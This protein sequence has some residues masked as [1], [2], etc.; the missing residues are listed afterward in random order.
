MKKFFLLFVLTF[1]L[2]L[3]H[4]SKAQGGPG[5][6]GSTENVFWFSS[7][8]FV[9][10]DG[11]NNVTTWRDQ[12][13]SNDANNNNSSTN[14]AF[15]AV[16]NVGGNLQP[17]ILFSS[18]STEFL[19]M[20]D[21]AS[22]NLTSITARTIFFVFRTG[23]DVAT[24]QYLYQQGA[25]VDGVFAYISGS[26]LTFGINSAS[27]NYTISSGVS[28]DTDYIVGFTY[29]G[30]AQTLDL[31]LN[32]TAATQTT[33]VATSIASHTNI[34]IGS[35]TAGT[36]FL[37]GHLA[38]IIYYDVAFNDAELRVVDNYLSEKYDIAI[39][40][41]HYTTADA[42]YGNN[43]VGISRLSGAEH[44]ASTGYGGSLYISE[45]TTD[46][47]TELIDDEHIYIGHNNNNQ[48]TTS[49]DMGAIANTE[50]Y[51]RVWYLLETG[52]AGA[53]VEFDL[54]ESGLY[55]AM[56]GDPSVFSLLFRA[57]VSGDFTDTDYTSAVKALNGD[58]IQ[59][60]IS[61]T[62][63]KS[64]YITI[65]VPATSKKWYV[66][67][68]GN[69]NDPNTW[70]LDPAGSIYNNPDGLTP[71]SSPTT[72]S[73]EVT[74]LSGK[75]VTVQ[76]N[77]M[78]GTLAKLTVDG[79]LDF[80][81]STGHGAVSLLEGSGVIKLSNDILPTF[82][83]ASNFTSTGSGAGTVE[84]YGSS[85]INL[86]ASS[87][88]TS[89][90]NLSLNFDANSDHLIVTTDITVNGDLTITT[91]DF[92]INDLSTTRL[93]IDVQG[94]LTVSANGEISVGTGAISA[95]QPVGPSDFHDTFHRLNLSGD[96]TN[97]GT[98]NFSNLT[99]YDFRNIPTNNDCVTV[100]FIGQSDNTLTCN[101]TT[102]F[103]DFVINKGN[104]K[105]YSLTVNPSAYGNFRVF[106]R[107]DVGND[108]NFDDPTIGKPIAII[109]GTLIVTGYTFIPSLSEGRTDIINDEGNR[110]DWIIPASSAFWINGPNVIVHGTSN[111]AADIVFIDTDLAPEV[112]NIVGVRTTRASQQSFIIMGEF[113][114]S[115]GIYDCR[116]APG[117][118]FSQYGS[119]RFIIEG[120][121]MKVSQLRN[122]N[123]NASVAYNQ[124]G[125][126][127]TVIGETEGG[128]TSVPTIG[129]F[130]FN[131][132]NGVFIM[133]GGNI[134]IKD[135][136]DTA[137]GDPGTVNGLNINVPEGNYNVT[138]GT[139]EID[140]E[141]GD[142]PSEGFEI[143]FT[144]NFYNLTISQ[145]DNDSISFE[146]NVVVTNDLILKAGTVIGM[147]G[148]DLTVGR[149][150]NV[151]AT[152]IYN[153]N[154]TSGSNTTTF[155][156]DAGQ[157]IT[158]AGTVTDNFYDIV[159]S[160]TGVKTISSA[161]LTVVNSLT[162]AS[163]ATLDDGGQNIIVQGSMSNSGTHQSTGSGALEF[164]GGT[165]YTVSG[166]DNGVFGDVNLNDGTND[167][168]FTADQAIVGTLTFVAD[169]QVLHIGTH[170]LVMQGAG[171]LISGYDSN[172][173]IQTDGNAS[174]GGLSIYIDGTGTFTFPIGTNVNNQGHTISLPPGTDPTRY[175][176]ADI[177][178]STFT[179]DGYIT[180]TVADDDIPSADPPGGGL[181]SY[182]WKVAHS[183]FTTVPQVSSY[184]FTHH[185][186][187][188]DGSGTGSWRCGKGL[189]D[190]PYTRT[191][192][193]DY[194]A[195]TNVIKF[196]DATLALEGAYYSAGA[197]NRF[198]NTPSIY[199][200]R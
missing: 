29:D 18:A 47:N 132:T 108:I 165:S 14:P 182:F 181:L 60:T 131:S 199:Y 63:L 39:L 26:N 148:N 53:V 121:D 107:N 166:D 62:D 113:K 37:D 88:L 175:T 149:N 128:N 142:L 101:A 28:A 33:S 6:V 15:D 25:S 195:S 106:G 102:N 46:G 161:D 150:F 55:A 81:S 83:D 95:G 9:E 143:S 85:D 87:G 198:N 172:N 169:D 190:T 110:G 94:D 119:A 185:E 34:T 21:D 22:I 189:S 100:S 35:S 82:T 10:Y 126:T 123:A 147:N 70:T 135:Y 17:A 191:T 30:T 96:F 40:N 42:T 8:K 103:Y 140:V 1:S 41:D 20:T 92:Q 45:N 158:L 145:D 90:Y 178:I 50:R 66:I 109:S 51:N 69:Y 93:I 68:D 91:G 16:A 43:L 74:I 188:L 71:D 177:T 67:N 153:R 200:S 124:S 167:V 27:S 157:T 146:S 84:Y 76:D 186:D 179:D 38:E 44:N 164:S 24:Q 130:D 139:I 78:S 170:S 151:E 180:I 187:D 36:D 194:T 3:S 59:F 196:D 136:N 12:A 86:T 57:G 97:N 127:I 80:V 176:P 73:D 173:F 137:E 23:S 138:G 7:D 54:I 134:V 152:A 168:I 155:N 104:D 49:L 162:I 98:V 159:F 58:R 193:S 19:D 48:S 32:G 4:D 65:G 112:L 64:G 192:Q 72:A 174:D 5:G 2:F 156:G 31:L 129:V 144:P 133:S 56:P 163:G 77:D 13:N 125:G 61:N 120:G 141:T 183:D 75:T 122:T 79:T 184:V 89:F 115:D 52:D 160:G 116:W 171:A 117:I 154:T 11:S 114:I 118:F 105:T 197:N 99:A 111:S